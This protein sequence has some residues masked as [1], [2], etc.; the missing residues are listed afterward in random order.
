MKKHPLRHFKNKISAV[1]L[2]GLVMGW[3]VAALAK[4]TAITITATN[5]VIG[6]GSFSVL[7]TCS[8]CTITVSPAGVRTASAGI[9]LTSA[10][11]GQAAAY[12]VTPTCNA[13]GCSAYTAVVT[14][15][16]ASLPAGSVTMS[17]GSFTLLQSA[18]LPPNTLSVG[19]TLTIP[20]SGSAA[21]AY[22]G[23][24]FTITTTP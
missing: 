12:T 1:F 16:S 13:G 4:T 21:G 20:S 19:A 5:S 8:N 15:S 18:T 2:L 23:A 11:P 3:P 9:V 10:A 6:F 7:P 17:V 22:T 24:A 14:P